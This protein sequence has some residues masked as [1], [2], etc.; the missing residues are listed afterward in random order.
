MQSN[1]PPSD[2]SAAAAETEH[3][4]SPTAAAPPSLVSVDVLAHWLDLEVPTDAPQAPEPSPAFA[5]L[6]DP[7]GAA[8]LILLDVRYV[9][10][11]SGA[12]HSSYVQGHLPG[13][14][15]VSMDSELSRHAGPREGRHPLPDPDRFADAVRMWGIS[16]GDA[17]VVYDDFSGMAAARAWWL[18][19]HAG[20]KNSV[21]LDGGLRAW[22]DAG[23][24]LQPGEVIPTPGSAHPSWG[25]MPVVDG[26]GAEA[27][28]AGGLLLDARA[29]ERYT[30]EHEPLDA[31]AG[32]IPGA[33]SAP[34]TA[35]LTEDG[36]L[37]PL[38]DLAEH[39]GA[40]GVSD[41]VPVA[42]YC[43]SG[44]T[45]AHLVLTLAAAGRHGVALF[46]GSWS[47]WSQNPDNPVAT[48]PEPGRS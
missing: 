35:T 21:V 41:D 11:H 30:G 32:H 6:D 10:G 37:R 25:R 34:S 5:S 19:R 17:I 22:R 29:H 14:V 12:D 23:L 3:A 27:I 28:A 15:Y 31:V 24:P 8:R 42:A 9:P 18:L 47:A 48:G 38:T 2:S 20:L 36:H 26:A 16:D 33:V 45:A 44:V 39:F 13:A 7:M 43:G 1:I 40:L 46:P 4:P